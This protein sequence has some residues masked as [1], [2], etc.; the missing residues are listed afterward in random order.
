MRKAKVITKIYVDEF[1]FLQILH[2]HPQILREAIHALTESLEFENDKLGRLTK[3]GLR[4]RRRSRRFFV[5]YIN[6][7]KNLN[8]EETAW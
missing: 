3:K 5:K 1:E 6:F 7:L 8:D 2:Q 4:F